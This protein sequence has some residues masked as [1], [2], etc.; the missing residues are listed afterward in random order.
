MKKISSVLCCM[1]LMACSW[2]SPNSSFYVMESSGLQPLSEKKI[3]VSVT[4]VKVPDM[5]NKSQ[6]VVSDKNSSQIQVLEFE[7]WGEVYPDMLQSTITNDLIAY[8]P[9]AYVK[10]TYFDGE[11]TLYSVN[12]EVNRLQAY[13]GDKVVLS[14]WWNIKDAK[15]N[16][17][18]KKQA[19]YEAKVSGNDIQDLVNAQAVAVH[20]LSQ[21]IALSL[22]K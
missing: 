4:K 22:T 19:V 18:T 16:I 6:M 9:N 10:S 20:E 15:G 21:D 2:R 8:L 7:R 14:G 1:L 11:N 17:V 3:S 5:L 13:K 12:V